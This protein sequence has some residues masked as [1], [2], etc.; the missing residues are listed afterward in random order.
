[1]S[2][3]A[4]QRKRNFKKTSEPR[5]RKKKLRR[6]RD[7]IFVVQ[8]HHARNLH[9]DF[10]LEWNGT[11]KS[12]AVPKGPSTDP[13]V[14]RLAV[15][16]EDHPLEYATFEGTIPE[17]Q[18]GAG[19]VYI[20]DHGT[21]HPDTDV[22]KGFVKGHLSFEL[23]G[24]KLRGHWDLI[25]TKIPGR[26]HQW[27]LIK[28]ED[29]YSLDAPKKKSSR[30]APKVNFIHPELA[31]LSNT[32]PS[33]REWV[34]EI[35]FDG[36]RIQAHLRNGVVQLFTRSGQNWT[37]QFPQLAENLKHIKVSSAIIDGEVVILDQKGRS[38]F[39]VLQN[40]LKSSETSA[41]Y[42][43][44]FDLL[45]KNETDLRNTPLWERKKELKDLIKNASPQVRYSED[46]VG[47]GNDLLKAAKDHQLEGIISKRRNSHYHSGR[48][49]NW[50]KVKTL[51]QQE[52]VIGGYT[53]GTGGRGPLGALLLGVYKNKKLQYVG[54]V[55]TGFTQA[56]L[57]EVLKNLKKLKQS[58][59]P[60]DT[61]SP[62]S[63][64]IHWVTPRLSANIT[65]SQW[66]DDELLRAPVFQGLREDKPVRQVFKESPIESNEIKTLSHPEKIL[67]RAEKITK[68]DVA[69]YYSKV[70]KRMIPFIAN[71]PL[72]LVRC[73]QGTSA[74]CF[75]QKHPSQITAAMRPFE[76][77]E[78]NGPETYVSIYNESGLIDLVQMNAFEIHC[79]NARGENFELPNQI[80]LDLDPGPGVSW[81]SVIKAA[82]DVKKILEQLYL[83]SFVKLSGGKGLHIHIPIKPIYSWDQIASFSQTIAR[84]MEQVSPNFYVSKM[85]KN[86]RA[87]KVF[88]DY[89]RNSRNATA[90]APYSLR[91]HEHSSVALP[92]T[93]RQ[94]QI[95]TASNQ[96]SLPKALEFISRQ[97][98]DPWPRYALLQQRIHLIEK[99]PKA[100]ATSLHP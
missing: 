86:L 33:G 92:L 78:R 35:K 23:K 80:V 91:A 42:Y 85:T 38:N 45:Y 59:S 64:N 37:H 3:K 24:K 14:K 66:T 89:F 9:Y 40:A 54:K 49:A 81:K 6:Q 57:Q 15:E 46:F 52:F 13:R 72:S 100:T 73:P 71:R 76:I 25:R 7:F 30:R 98:N 75:F 19:E 67:Y 97:K 74:H 50:I 31:Q 26:N 41:L 32:V 61:K 39:Q 17:H 28:K 8:E 48:N 87:K 68:Q 77:T 96:F 99:K 58:Q 63:R 93:W 21:W 51:K 70:A 16:V 43:Y 55:G 94:L 34:H 5:V 4:Y 11:L 1:M 88:I 22:A 27:L 69:L 18:Y 95:T 62:P 36:Y 10:R 47:N 44:A 65:F 2:L 60:F 90:V 56:S 84:H 79:S 20:W 53:E 83:K 29:S 12:W 82:F